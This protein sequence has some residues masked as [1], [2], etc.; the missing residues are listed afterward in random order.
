MEKRGT[1][2][3]VLV[4]D[5]SP[6]SR[7]ILIEALSAGEFEVVGE[8][9]G[10][11]TVLELYGQRRPDVVTMDIAMPGIDGLGCTTKLREMYPEAKVVIVS[12]MQD[13]EMV[14][15]AKRLGVCGYIQK[16]V[17]TDELIAALREAVG[18]R[19]QPE[20]LT[21]VF[22]GVFVGAMEDNL[23]RHGVPFSNPKIEPGAPGGRISS[24]VT[25]LVGITGAVN[26][27][28]SFDLPPRAADAV[29]AKLLR[30]QPKH[31]EEVLQVLAEFANIVAGHATSRLN[32]QFKGLM[33]RVTPPGI[34]CGD[35]FRVHSPDLKTILWTADVLAG[36]MVM[37][38]GFKKE[39]VAWM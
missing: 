9:D 36:G 8:A 1:K 5:D 6:F 20:E 31:Q 24:G 27:R 7:S 32:K 29:A 2:I 18:A 13:E 26:G 25:I 19:R 38:V 11:E 3:K 30:R 16:P 28:M 17:Q 37:A 4:V 15:E 23:S 39:E 22:P 34:I 35:Q 33:L 10:L 14:L 21:A 12:S